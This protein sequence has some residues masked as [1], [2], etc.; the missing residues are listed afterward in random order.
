MNLAVIGAGPAGLA[1]ALLAAARLPQAR[2]H[3]FDTRPLDR[4][5][6]GDARTLALNL[7]SV[8]LLERLSAWQPAVAQPIR[9]VHVSQAPPSPVAGAVHLR[10]VDLGVP[11][12]GAVL[13]YGALVAPLQQRWLDVAASEPERLFTRFGT[14]VNAIRTEP[15]SVEL[16]SGDAHLAERFDLAVVAEGGVFAEQDRKRLSRDYH[17][18]AWVGSVRLAPPGLQGLAIERFTR[19]GPLALL[20]LPDDAQGPRAALVWCRPQAEDDI[21]SLTDAQRL[22]VIQQQL[23]DVAGRLTG[24]SALKCFALGLNA[25]TRLLQGRTLRIGNAAQTLHPVAGQGLNLGL[26]DAQALVDAL[27]DAAEQGQDLDAALARV[28][29]QRAPDRWPMIAAT[30]FLARSFAWRLP[31]LPGLRG[32]ALAGLEFATPL[33]TALARR[34]MF[35][36]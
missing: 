24:I 5:V 7:G 33:K 19:N 14:A 6:S 32:L 12:L 3:L 2:I 21:A 36:G 13:P 15:G 16:D 34:M 30:D 9:T 27:R 8:R 11:Q 35:G 17:Q 18:N 10:A 23:P 22:V 26:R 31:G 25:E 4:D 29:R 20:P 1:L 28:D